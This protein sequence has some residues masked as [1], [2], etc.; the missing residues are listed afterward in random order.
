MLDK[1]RIITEA[2]KNLG[3]LNDAQINE[4]LK[5]Q[6][7]TQERFSKV[8]SELGYIS[9]E[10]LAKSLLPQFGILPLE[11]SK[12]SF[13]PDLIAEIPSE[14]A[15]RHRFIPLSKTD[16][17]LKIV[18]DDP[19]NFLAISNLEKFCGRPLELELTTKEEFDKMFE[20]IY[21]Q[22]KVKGKN[23]DMMVEKIGKQSLPLGEAAI[24]TQEKVSKEE[25][26][27]IKLV[28]LLITE[29]IR[30]RASD[31]HIEPLE[32]KLRIRYRI[33]GVLHEV[34]GPPQ[35]DRRCSPPQGHD[36]RTT[37]CCL[38]PRGRRENSKER[39]G[40]TGQGFSQRLLILLSRI[41][42]SKNNPDA[43]PSS[44]VT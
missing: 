16:S 8:L 39:L 3:V 30:N 37:R 11:I 24:L 1:E 13:E 34:P 7:D 9:N 44:G 28:S 40:R 14:L 6:A 33:D 43:A 15:K 22:K 29:A 41:S 2:L 32:K 26:P 20:S 31:V 5:V 18:T 42:R 19:F 17:T 25:A 21:G 4:S 35:N 23:I 12:Y 36:Q 38:P 10:N 27:V